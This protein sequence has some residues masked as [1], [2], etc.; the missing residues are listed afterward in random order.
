MKTISTVLK[1]EIDKAGYDNS[2]T[3]CETLITFAQD[4]HKADFKPAI[5][6]GDYLNEGLCGYIYNYFKKG[7]GYDYCADKNWLSTTDVVD[8][9][10]RDCI[11]TWPNR[12]GCHI[13]PCNVNKDEYYELAAAGKLYEGSQLE[14]RRNLAEHIMN[15]CHWLLAE[16]LCA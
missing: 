10:I 16:K 7:D 3:A 12:I 15:Y 14:I 6:E 2:I 9:I 1:C 8:Q 11:K 13:Y 5:V 4:L